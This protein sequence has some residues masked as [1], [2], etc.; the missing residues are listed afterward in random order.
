MNK[1]VS[2]LPHAREGVRVWSQ[3]VLRCRSDV[4]V[5]IALTIVCR[6][7]TYPKP[8]P[9]Q[10]ILA[11]IAS[12]PNN[13]SG[14]L[15]GTPEIQSPPWILRT[16]LGRV[17]EEP[18][19]R[20]SAWCTPVICFISWIYSSIRV[21]GLGCSAC[22]AARLTTAPRQI[23]DPCS[24]RSKSQRVSTIPSSI[25]QFCSIKASSLISHKRAYNSEQQ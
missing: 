16:V 17:G 6:A 7:V 20:G 14:Y 23:P 12:S 9:V 21:R 18:V 24:T 19:F 13:A 8:K 2:P 11:T 5:C 15:P 10:P 4:A 25:G 3:V 1:E 22:I